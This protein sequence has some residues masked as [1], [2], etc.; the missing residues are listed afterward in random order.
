[1]PYYEDGTYM[2]AIDGRQNEASRGVGFHIQLVLSCRS[3]LQKMI[4]ELLAAGFHSSKVGRSTY[5]H[6]G[7]NTN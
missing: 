4:V 1:M 2:D 7:V 5:P 3:L 6:R